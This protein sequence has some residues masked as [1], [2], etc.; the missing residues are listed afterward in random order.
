MAVLGKPIPRVNGRSFATGSHRF[1]DDIAAPQMAV[2]KVLLR[3]RSI[4][5]TLG[6]LDS[7]AVP[8]ADAAVVAEKNFSGAAAGIY[9]R[10]NRR[11]H[12]GSGY[13]NFRCL[14]Q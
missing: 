5:A 1:T 12:G 3:L 9:E 11:G 6:S 8:K 7:S 10:L 4:G 14:Y 13:Q 2:G